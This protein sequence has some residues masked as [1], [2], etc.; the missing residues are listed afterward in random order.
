MITSGTDADVIIDGGTTALIIAASTIDG[1]LTLTKWSTQQVSP[2]VVRSRLAATLQQRPMRV[3]V[4][5]IWDQLAVDG[6]R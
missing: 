6:T 1:D 3:T 2:T 4:S 5:L